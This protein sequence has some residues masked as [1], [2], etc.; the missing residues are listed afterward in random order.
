MV[1]NLKV[2][3]RNA[4]TKRIIFLKIKKIIPAGQYIAILISGFYGKAF[5]LLVNKNMIFKSDRQNLFSIYTYVVNSH[6]TE[7]HI[8][9]DTK[10]YIILFKNI[11]LGYVVEYEV[12]NCYIIYSA[13]YL[14]TVKKSK[15]A[16]G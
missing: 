13:E 16:N 6:I 3:T 12:D 7:V 8:K 1:L 2:R 11:K 9:N 4:E 10:K 15:N 14:F 5:L